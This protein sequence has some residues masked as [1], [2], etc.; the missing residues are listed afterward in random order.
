MTILVAVDEKPGTEKVLSVAYD[1]ATTYDDELVAVHVFPEEDVNDHFDSLREIPEF[2][3]L[4][5]SQES[6]R[7]RRIA[8]SFIDSYL[9]EADSNRVRGTGA[10]GNPADCIVEEA[11]RLDARYVVIGGRRRSPTGKALFG[12]VTQTVLLRSESPVLTVMKD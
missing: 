3:D 7:A 2:Q 4:S 9:P 5:F 12:S 1:L 8:E 10:I 11:D 6:D